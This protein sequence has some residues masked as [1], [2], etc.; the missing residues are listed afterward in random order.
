MLA[1]Q[2]KNLFDLHF[3]DRVI[4]HNAS[5]RRLL[6]NLLHYQIIFG[7]K[8]YIRHHSEKTT[9]FLGLLALHFKFTVLLLV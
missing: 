8:C 9:C 7:G 3:Q 4:A 2:F 1:V 5:A 6:L